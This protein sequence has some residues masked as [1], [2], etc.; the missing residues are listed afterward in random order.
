MPDMGRAEWR[1]PKAPQTALLTAG[2]PLEAKSFY[3][4]AERA[5]LVEWR[6]YV[7]TSGSGEI[8]RLRRF[9][10]AGLRFGVNDPTPHPFMTHC[11]LYRSNLGELMRLLA[12]ALNAYA[13]EAD[14]AVRVRTGGLR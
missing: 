9:T 13:D 5:G 10:D 11:K 4:L 2:A 12:A 6:E 3:L 14:A 1:L 7:S 8:K